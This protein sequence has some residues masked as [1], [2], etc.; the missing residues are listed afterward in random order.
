MTTVA[1]SKF[2]RSFPPHKLSRNLE[3]EQ[4]G[5]TTRL[6]IAPE[7]APEAFH[8]EEFGYHGRTCD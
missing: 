7:S 2:A 4:G 3:M 6:P 1:P 8:D 5:G